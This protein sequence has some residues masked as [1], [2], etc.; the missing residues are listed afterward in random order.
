MM[1]KTLQVHF[2]QIQ[3]RTSELIERISMLDENILKLQPRKGE[4]SILQVL[5]HL[6]D[7]EEGTLNYCKKKVKAGNSIKNTT[8]ISRVKMVFFNQFLRLKIR[9]KM[10]KYLSH[11]SVDLEFI[12]VCERWQKVRD[13]IRKFLEEYPDALSSK[14]IFKHPVAGRISMSQTLIFFDAHIA[15][16]EHQVRRIVKKIKSID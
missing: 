6:I 7:A 9:Y 14:A 1:N 13:S 4:W 5:Q 16:H 8:V 12:E 3:T 11:P 10:P 2:D 15:H